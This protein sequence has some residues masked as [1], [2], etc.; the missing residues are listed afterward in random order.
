MSIVQDLLSLTH[1]TRRCKHGC[2]FRPQSQ[3]QHGQLAFNPTFYINAPIHHPSCCNLHTQLPRRS[4][5]AQAGGQS[6][7]IGI[8][9][10]EESTNSDA[11][12]PQIPPRNPA[13]LDQTNS[14][15]PP[16]I[17]PRNPARLSQT[18]NPNFSPNTRSS[19]LGFVNEDE[20]PAPKTQS[21]KNKIEAKPKKEE[22]LDEWQH[23]GVEE[24]SYN[25]LENERI[26]ALE[27]EKRIAE[28][29]EKKVINE[30]ADELIREDEKKKEQE[31]EGRETVVWKTID[32]DSLGRF[33][34]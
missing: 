2:R 18:N 9:N 19:L 26:E 20:S 30:K 34:E 22:P 25:K 14:P 31:G 24:E 5:S 4:N 15:T 28:E 7:H 16:P 1:Q 32:D 17:P 27:E 8:P 11:S 12:T 21:S 13:R 23:V 6:Q 10:M 29:A 3:S 33:K